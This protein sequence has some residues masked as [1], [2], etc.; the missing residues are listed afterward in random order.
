MLI[1]SYLIFQTSPRINSILR[2]RFKIK[3][4][5]SLTTIEASFGVRYTCVS[6]GNHVTSPH[7]SVA[8]GRCLVE[9]LCRCSRKKWPTVCSKH[10]QIRKNFI[11][12]KSFRP[13]SCVSDLQKART[14]RDYTQDPHDPNSSRRNLG[15]RTDVHVNSNNRLSQLRITRQI[16]RSHIAKCKS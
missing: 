14:P 6:M 9:R 13:Q 12:F 15:K 5:M 11:A 4:E 2:F 7:S 16:C 3:N 10:I 8:S 1:I